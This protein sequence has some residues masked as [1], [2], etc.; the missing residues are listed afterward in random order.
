LT[1]PVG[2]VRHAEPPE[3]L[4]SILCFRWYDYWSDAGLSDYMVTNDGMLAEL[5]SGPRSVR[6]QLPGEYEVYTA[7]VK[8]TE[9]LER[10]SPQSLRGMLRGQHL[11]AWYFLWPVVCGKGARD[12]GSVG[13]REF[14]LTCQR[15]ERSGI[16][17][18]WPHASHLYRQLCGKL[19]IPQMCLCK[20]Y[21][22]PPTTRVH[23]AEFRRRP[24]EAAKRALG[25]LMKLRATLWGKEA[26]Q[27]DE[28][29]GVAKLGFSW[30]GG[31]VLP[32]QGLDGLVQSL[33]RLF[34][35]PQCEQTV[36][37]VQERV[38]DVVGEF[39]VLCFHDRSRGSFHKEPV[40]VFNCKRD[41]HHVHDCDVGDFTVASATAVPEQAVA[42][43]LFKGDAEAQRT[44][45]REALRLAGHWL[46]WFLTESPE[47]PQCTRIDFLVARGEAKSVEVWT[48][49]VGECGASLC[50]V[51][52]HGR[53]AVAVN[54]A[55]QLD[56]SGRFPTPLPK[57]M[58]RNYGWKS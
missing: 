47:P 13:E 4:L 1:V 8:D 36:C 26:V 22:V 2:L 32:F 35:R 46:Q 31:D 55:M 53:N 34:G 28:F 37:L 11:V 42:R 30:C 33:E 19:W 49:E 7:F 23:F 50:S 48:C 58:P 29:R 45:E 51:E 38:L 18:G 57:T 16:R 40:W 5:L 24:L 6:R 39:R 14:F 21:R 56:R 17:T 9:D 20:R 52:V 15:M 41:R 25:W 10:L 44:A 43:M 12:P 3:P 27:L 54:Y